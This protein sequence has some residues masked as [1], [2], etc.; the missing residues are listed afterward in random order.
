MWLI[1]TNKLDL[2][3]TNGLFKQLVLYSWVSM[4]LTHLSPVQYWFIRTQS[5][6]FIRKMNV[7]MPQL[8]KWN[9]C[10]GEWGND[11]KFR[12]LC[13]A[14]NWCLKRL[15][16][17]LDGVTTPKYKLLCSITSNFFRKRKALALNWDR[18]CHLALCLRLILFHSIGGRNWQLISPYFA[19]LACLPYEWC[20]VLFTSGVTNIDLPLWEGTV[21]S[22]SV[23]W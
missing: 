9:Q 3:L 23:R 16:H 17:P 18:C 14:R 15:Y 4:K 22:N 6:I 7:L 13:Q 1:V 20:N 2:K 12:D 8:I 5:R 19:Q 10:K 21:G 11:H